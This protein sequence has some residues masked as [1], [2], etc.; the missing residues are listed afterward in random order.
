MQ[1]ILATDANASFAIFTYE[2]FG[3]NASIEYIIGFDAGN[4]INYTNIRSG[5]V[6]PMQSS[7]MIYRIDG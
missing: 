1:L 5:R 4:Q 3:Y 2:G 6:S 7:T